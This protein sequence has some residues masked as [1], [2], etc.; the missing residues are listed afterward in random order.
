MFLGVEYRGWGWEKKRVDGDGDGDDPRYSPPKGKGKGR[1]LKVHG[2]IAQQEDEGRLVA[3]LALAAGHPDKRRGVDAFGRGF[4]LHDNPQYMLEPQYNW[5]TAEEGVVIYDVQDPTSS[6]VLNGHL[7]KVNNGDLFFEYGAEITEIEIEGCDKETMIYFQDKDSDKEKENAGDGMIFWRW[8][9]D[10]K[11][12]GNVR[13]YPPMEPF[14]DRLKSLTY[15]FLKEMDK[16]VQ[17][18]KQTQIQYV[19]C[20]KSNNQREFAK[21]DVGVILPQLV[22][23]GVLQTIIIKQNA[24][25]THLGETEIQQRYFDRCL[26]RLE[27]IPTQRL[28]QYCTAFQFVL[29]VSEIGQDHPENEC[30]NFHKLIPIPGTDSPSIEGVLAKRNDCEDN[31]H[32]LFLAKNKQYFLKARMMRVLPG[33][34][35]AAGSATGP[36][37]RSAS[38]RR[39]GTRPHACCDTTLPSS[40]AR[41]FIAT[42]PRSRCPSNQ[43]YNEGSSRNSTCSTCSPGQRQRMW[44]NSV[45]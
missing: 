37:T 1:I 8:R 45:I 32:A 5:N 36:F 14:R 29:P 15:H 25:P 43:L 10:P 16:M 44:T 28:M 6:R 23:S 13:V 21:V 33:T 12:T 26:P 27:G 17:D 7:L 39:Q 22:A 34:G 3:C 20:I 40:S 24:Y 18:L 30:Q 42:V 9:P 35:R 31:S 41:R 38:S 19:R 4:R 2:R 11:Q